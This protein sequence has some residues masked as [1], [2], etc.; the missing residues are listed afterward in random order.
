[1]RLHIHHN[2]LH[3][4]GDQPARILDNDRFLARDPFDDLWMTRPATPLTNVKAKDDFYELAV[5]LPGFSKDEISIE[6]KDQML[7]IK[8]E[9]KEESEEKED[10][11]HKK[12]FET[13]TLART[14]S[15]PASV[16]EDEILA[17]LET[18]ILKISIPV[19]PT[20]FKRKIEVL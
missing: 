10:S 11:F 16:N 15:L 8:A 17:N 6:L 9:K 12:E 2:G 20:S 19:S 14:F 7:I 4:I 18:G 5:A 3:R 13:R 1:M